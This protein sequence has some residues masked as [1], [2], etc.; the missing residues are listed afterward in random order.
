MVC[1]IYYLWLILNFNGWLCNNLWHW[2][3]YKIIL[4]S[5][6]WRKMKW[7][8]FRPWINLLILNGQS[9]LESLIVISNLIWINLPLRCLTYVKSLKSRLKRLNL[10]ILNKHILRLNNILI[11][12]LYLKWI[13]LQ[14]LFF[15]N[16][17]I[18]LL[19]DYFL[20][21]IFIWYYFYFYINFC[22]DD[23]IGLLKIYLLG[24]YNLDTEG[25][26]IFWFT[27][28]SV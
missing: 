23:L 24:L 12:N 16:Y 28:R 21:W 15:Y 1:L 22:S 10:R 4:I 3:S 2:L 9:L 5:I 17:K 7:L 14:I 6:L 18:F 27:G 25:C 26:S 20:W 11:W 8:W 13:I 19:I